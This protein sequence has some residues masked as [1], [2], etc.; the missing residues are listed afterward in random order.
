MNIIL[1]WGEI[2]HL[3]LRNE[4]RNENLFDFIAQSVEYLNS[5]Q[6]DVGNFNLFFLYRLSGFVGFQ[7]NHSSWQE[8]YVFNVYD[9][10]FYPA[11]GHT[12]SVS[13]PHTAEIIHRLCSCQLEEVKD[14][15]LNRQARNILLEVILL[16]YTTHLNVDFNIKS[17]QVI[18]EVFS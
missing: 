10:S 5:T 14:I 15:Q 4:G 3:L 2:L 18:R 7:V 13:G 16:F 11:D 17:I 12:P 8:G 9:G 1:L 6:T